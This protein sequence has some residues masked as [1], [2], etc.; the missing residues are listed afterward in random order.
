MNIRGVVADLH[1]DHSALAISALARRSVANAMHTATDCTGSLCRREHD[2]CAVRTTRQIHRDDLSELKEVR[3]EQVAVQPA[4]AAFLS[5][6]GDVDAFAGY[7]MLRR[8][9]S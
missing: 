9:Q 6:H 4:L 8:R 7:V 1:V 3:S 2:A 5:A